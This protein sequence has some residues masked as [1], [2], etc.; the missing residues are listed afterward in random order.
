[1]LLQNQHPLNKSLMVSVL[2]VPNVGKSSLINCLLGMDLSAVAQKAQTT[3][4]QYHCVLSVDQTEIIL[5]DTPGVHH[6]SKELNKRLK[7]QVQMGMEGVDLNLVLLSLEGKLISQLETIVSVL[8]LEKPFAPTWLVLTKADLY[9]QDSQNENP[10]LHEIVEQAQKIIP[11]IE[12]GFI[13]SSRRQTNIHLLTGALMDRA[14]PG[15][16]L[17]LDGSISNKN[18]RFFVAEYI[19]EQAFQVLKDEIPHELAVQVEEYRE[20]EK[21]GK[22]GVYISACLLVNRP[23]QRAIV[24]GSKGSMIKNIG[25]QGRKKIEQMV[26]SKVYLNLHVKV[27]PKWFKNN[28]ILEELGLPRAKDSTRVWRGG[29]G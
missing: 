3:R 29:R 5:V 10:A 17:Y 15:P 28:F 9:S 27:S 24:V 11:D 16:H 13:I 22:V 6:S 4:N 7:H 14:K 20:V 19:R 1:M 18:E 8:E 25:L 23:S 2:G 12:R 26:R 21:G